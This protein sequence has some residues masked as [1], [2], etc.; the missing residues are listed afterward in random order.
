MIEVELKDGTGRISEI[1]SEE[2]HF[3]LMAQPRL[4]GSAEQGEKVQASFPIKNLNG[5]PRD[6]YLR[7]QLLNDSREVV[8]DTRVDQLSEIEGFTETEIPILLSL[9]SNLSPGRYEVKLIISGDEAETIS[10]P[11]NLI[12]YLEA[13]LSRW[14]KRRKSR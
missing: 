9:P 11:V 3:Q 8:M 14:R 12:H 7:V 6:C 1:Y 2:P 4:I 13:A 10:Y 5:V